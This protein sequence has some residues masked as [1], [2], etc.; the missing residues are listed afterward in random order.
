MRLNRQGFGQRGVFNFW[1]GVNLPDRRPGNRKSLA[2]PVS[3]ESA[4][5]V[6]PRE[7]DRSRL[8]LTT[9]AGRRCLTDTFRER[10]T[11][12]AIERRANPVPR[13]AVSRE[14]KRRRAGDRWDD[15]VARVSQLNPGS[16]ATALATESQEPR[17]PMTQSRGGLPVSVAANR[18]A[19]RHC[20]PSLR[21]L[22]PSRRLVADSIESVHAST[23][24]ADSGC[25]EGRVG[26]R[27]DEK[28]R[29]TVSEE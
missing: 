18:L 20:A 21:T 14:S 29:R 25:T 1:R 3:A 10:S 23:L 26:N 8:S 4:T 27:R 9:T 22:S 24:T 17:V 5:G 2:P 13:E 15:L 11:V 19:R 28:L 16:C 7:A 12:S 6:P